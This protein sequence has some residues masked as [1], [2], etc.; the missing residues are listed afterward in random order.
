MS[1]KKERKE[2]YGKSKSTTSSLQFIFRFFFLETLIKEISRAEL[3]TW[4][5]YS[6]VYDDW[7]ISFPSQPIMWLPLSLPLARFDLAGISNS[8]E[9]KEKER[10][11]NKIRQVKYDGTERFDNMKL[12]LIKQY[13]VRFLMIIISERSN[14]LEME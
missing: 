10:R 14:Y 12:Y 2:K 7:L 6:W 9:K 13:K 1:T 3:T 5:E 11:K 8:R 4:S